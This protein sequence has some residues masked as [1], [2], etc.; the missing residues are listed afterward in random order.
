MQTSHT[1]SYSRYSPSKKWTPKTNPQVK[2]WHVWHCMLHL[3]GRYKWPKKS[4]RRWS[5]PE[6]RGLSLLSL[7]NSTAKPPRGFLREFQRCA[8]QAIR[9]KIWDFDPPPDCDLMFLKYVIG[10][11]ICLFH[12]VPVY[13]VCEKILRCN[14]GWW[15]AHFPKPV[16][17]KSCMLNHVEIFLPIRPIHVVYFH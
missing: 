14:L 9:I 17:Q 8:G 13:L 1:Y 16:F 12:F 7:I 6:V 15:T 10:P 11:S 2:Y 4:M 3:T 5:L